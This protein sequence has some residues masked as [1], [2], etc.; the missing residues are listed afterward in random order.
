MK[1]TYLILAGILLFGFAF[2]QTIVK[3]VTSTVAIDGQLD[4]SFWDITTPITIKHYTSDNTASFGVLWDDNYLYIGVSVIDGSLYMNGRQGFY[5]DGIEIYIDGNYSK[6]TSVEQDDRRFVKPVKSYWIQEADGHIDGVLYK[7]VKTNDGY[8]MEFAIP[9]SNFNVTPTATMNIGFNLAV[10]DEDDTND[11]NALPKLIWAGSSNYYKNPSTWGVLN[12]S[13]QTVSYSSKYIALLT[14]DGGEFCINGKISEIKWVS[15]GISNINIDYSINNGD[16]WN[17]IVTNLAASPASYN[18]SVSATPSAECLIRVSDTGAPVVNDVSESVFTVSAPLTAV[19]PLIPNIWKNF[20]WPYNAYYPEADDGINGHIGNACGHS[21][22]ARILHYWEFPVIGN[23]ELTF[24]DYAGYTWSA[25][26]GATTYNY[27]NMPSLLSSGNTEDEYKDVAT[28][29]YHAATSMHDVYGSGR[30]LDNM[31]YAMSHYFKYKVSTPTLRSD[32][33]KAEWINILINELDNGRVLLID[34]MTPEVTGE[35]CES[36]WYS[37]HWFHVDGYNE[38][39]LFH[40][41]L[42]FGDEDGWFDIEKLFDFYL[43]NGVLVGLEPDLNGKELSLQSLNGG[44]VLPVEQ[45]VQINWSSTDIA[46]VKIEYTIDNGQNWVEIVSSTSASAGTYTWTTP[47]TLSYEC[48]IKI[49]DTDDINVY[50]KSDNTFRIATPEVELTYPRDGE[51]F[52]TNSPLNITWN[53]ALV[54]DVKLEYSMDNG[55][56]WVEIA[57][58]TPASAG[59]YNWTIPG[60]TSVN[61]KI[62]ITDISNSTLFDENDNV[63]RILNELSFALNFDADNDFVKFSGFAIPQN[64]LTIEAWIKPNSLIR[65]STIVSGES[66][67]SGFN[68]RVES[69][70]SLLYGE[71]QQWAYLKSDPNSIHINEWTHVAV[72]IQDSEAKLYVNGKVVANNTL[73]TDKASDAIYIGSKKVTGGNPF[74]GVIDEVRI[75]SVARTQEELVVNSTNYLDATVSGLVSCWRMNENTG[76]TC[77]DVTGSYNGQLGST[78]ASDDNDPQI[79]PTDWPYS[80]E[81]LSLASPIGGEFFVEGD[82]TKITWDDT[83]I[84]DIKI[85]YSVNNGSDWSDIAGSVSASTGSYDWTIP[86]EI[87]DQCLVRISNLS[88]ASVFDVIKDVFEI[89]LSSN[90]GGPYAVDDNT[91]LLFHF[92]RD[93]VNQSSLS[94]DGT[95]QGDNISYSETPV[96]NM[97]MCAE[98]D[99]SSYVSIPHNE[100]LNLLDNWTIEAWVNFISIGTGSSVSPVILSKSKSADDNYALWYNNNNSVISGQFSDEN[101]NSVYVAISNVINTGVW[102]H[103]TYIRDNTNYVH[104]MIIRDVNKTIIAEHEYTYGESKSHPQVNTNEIQIGCSIGLN[105]YFFNGYLDEVR[106][107]SVVRSFEDTNTAIDEASPNRISMYPN[108]ASQTVQVIV[109]TAGDLSIFDLSGRKVYEKVGFTSVTID[110]SGYAKGVYIVRFFNESIKIFKLVIE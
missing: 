42:G 14:P 80:N 5:D 15:D 62:R 89:G 8:S 47:N 26:F 57:N 60:T 86:N 1:T 109:P 52:L 76:Q 23:D 18:W 106:I 4:E 101:L 30:D 27:D 40:G 88:D 13:N 64:D 95:L 66:G 25:N 44:E 37:G 6:G 108:P 75:W 78:P 41:V 50:Y 16:T 82:V 12:L 73:N 105:G 69:D 24:T 29:M 9:W 94:D 53:S 93:L 83:S 19:N 28:L 21:S 70:G 35:W 74:R 22:L 36:N 104:K 79:L 103:I 11:H 110:V 100:N 7:W 107:S 54:S 61:C 68:F 96:A 34:G 92:E 98:F 39:G 71:Y 49:T 51:Q 81:S 32:Y 33:T 31:S 97:G 84:S 38:D 2:S 58:S 85:E 43:N 46:N 77:F 99:G 56:S 91:I 17:S 102:Y 48:K 87:S 90:E 45:A 59:S 65:T 10:N 3:K 20:I 67:I 63:F 72:T 55:V